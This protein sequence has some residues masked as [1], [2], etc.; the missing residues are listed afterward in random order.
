MI[1]YGSSFL[2]LQIV[3]NVQT[4]LQ[5]QLFQKGLYDFS[6]LQETFLFQILVAFYDRH[7]MGN[8]WH[9]QVTFRM[10]LVLCFSLVIN[11]PNPLLFSF[12]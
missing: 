6:C 3:A 5:L 12:P 4:S 2:F 7:L 1:K 8:S 10:L 11:T 9:Y